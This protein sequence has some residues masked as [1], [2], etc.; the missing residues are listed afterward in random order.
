MNPLKTSVCMF[1]VLLC[2]ATMSAH[3]ANCQT[4]EF[5][6]EVLA[7]FPNIRQACLGVIQ[8][9]DEQRAV[10]KTRLVKVYP[11][12]DNRVQVK[13]AMPDGSYTEP[14]T[15]T[16]S[17]NFRAVVD[18][19]PVRVENLATDQDVNVY[20]KVQEPMIALE[21]AEPTAP[22]VF[23]PLS[24]EQ[25]T[26]V[27]SAAKMPR[28]GGNRLNLLWVG[29]ALAIAGNGLSLL[30]TYVLRRRLSNFAAVD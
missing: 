9:G 23:S 3:A 22:T 11:F 15:I 24:A 17:P 21:P 13:I 12:P 16:T 27:A 28:T 18:G 10:F 1:A 29:F 26:H 2:G 20:I 30:L 7:K 19:K 6:N 14:R 5:S 4:V 25:P 8:S